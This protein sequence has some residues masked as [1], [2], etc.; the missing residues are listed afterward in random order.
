MTHL[1][2]SKEQ[3]K[4]RYTFLTKAT[5]YLMYSAPFF[6]RLELDRIS[7]SGSQ[8]TDWCRIP[9]E[10][11]VVLLI[12]QIL[13]PKFA[14]HV[15]SMTTP[16]FKRQDRLIIPGRKARTL[17]LNSHPDRSIN[18]Q[19][20]FLPVLFFFYPTCKKLVK[21]RCKNEE[22]SYIFCLYKVRSYMSI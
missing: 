18:A 14:V 20:Y 22:K 21:N 1:K 19:L 6:P 8:I 17:Y 16:S 9:L 12:L 15:V 3:V 5:H 2:E 11:T 13:T 7:W 4:A 10:I